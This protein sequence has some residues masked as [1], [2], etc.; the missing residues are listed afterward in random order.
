M[1]FIE[2]DDIDDDQISEIIPSSELEM[3]WNWLLSEVKPRPADIGKYCLFDHKSWRDSTHLVETSQMLAVL[4]IASEIGNHKSIIEMANGSACP[5]VIWNGTSL[6]N[7][8]AAVVKSED[9]FRNHLSEHLAFWIRL[10]VERK[11]R[12]STS[13]SHVAY[14]YSKPNIQPEDK[15]PDGIY[16]EVEPPRIE[17]QSVKNNLTNPKSYISSSS[18]RNKGI[19]KSKKLLDDFWRLKHKNDGLVRLEQQLDSLVSPLGLTAQEKVKIALIQR[20][21]YNAVVVANDKFADE[22]LFE[23]YEHVTVDKT[24]RIA[25]YIG[26]TNWKK[27]AA[28]TWKIVKSKL[29]KF[30]VA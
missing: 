6:D 13:N 20:A 17:I 11:K 7:D 9:R 26:S 27:L 4:Y 25:T 30:G 29:S 16:L 10:A 5:S 19:A 2:L 8:V 14:S 1:K 15:G 28:E 24:K 21:A 3:A 23:G 12:K 22:S 18:L